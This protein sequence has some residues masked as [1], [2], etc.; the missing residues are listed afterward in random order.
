MLTYEDGFRNGVEEATRPVS[1]EEMSEA[2][3]HNQ[4]AL[5]LTNGFLSYRRKSLL[6]KKVTKWIIIVH[7]SYFKEEGVS[8]GRLWD[9]ESCARRYIE[10]NSGFSP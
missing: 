4:A 8:Q 10:L 3:P 1:I 2:F 7:T 6:T 5:G 9:S